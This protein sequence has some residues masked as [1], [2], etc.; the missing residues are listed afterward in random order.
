MK[1]SRYT[2]KVYPAGQ[3]RTTYRT[4]EISGKD[5]LDTIFARKSVRAYTEQNVTPEQV[6]D[7]ANRATAIARQYAPEQIEE[8]E[9]V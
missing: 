4:M 3:G 6:Q 7:I 5:T 9:G 2:L 8:I 1:M